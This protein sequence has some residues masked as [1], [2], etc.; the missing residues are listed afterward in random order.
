[1]DGVSKEL[2]AFID[3]VNAQLDSNKR[4]QA[5]LKIISQNINDRLN[6]SIE[7][8][9]ALENVAAKLI[10]AAYQQPQPQPQKEKTLD[11]LI[12]KLAEIQQVKGIS[13]ANAFRNSRQINFASLKQSNDTKEITRLYDEACSYL[14]EAI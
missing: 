4:L 13:A 7:C 5:E 11:D 10:A 12:A 9:K 8:T 14:I 1:M 6:A 3:V 2:L